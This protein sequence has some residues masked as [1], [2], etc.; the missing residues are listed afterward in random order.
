MPTKSG[1]IINIEIKVTKE[2]YEKLLK[3]KG[4]RTWKELLFENCTIPNTLEKFGL[5]NE[6][7]ALA[8]DIL[9]ENYDDAK[10][11]CLSILEW[12]NEKLKEKGGKTDKS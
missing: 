3:K 12:I 1:D 10:E 9:L 5:I 2:E 11:T 6:I 4:N 8:V 7:E